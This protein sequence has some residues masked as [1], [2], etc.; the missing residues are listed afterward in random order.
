M[1]GSKTYVS[2]CLSSSLER[3]YRR[4][5]EPFVTCTGRTLSGKVPY[6]SFSLQLW[7]YDMNDSTRS[8]RPCNF[9]K[10][11]LNTLYDDSCHLSPQLADMV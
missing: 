6:E 2:F 11:R 10:D 3:N 9:A 4:S 8:G 7:K 1:S 5:P